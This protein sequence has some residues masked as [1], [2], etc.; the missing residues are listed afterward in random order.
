MKRPRILALGEILWDLFPEGERLGGAPANFACHVA[1]LGGDVSILSA[2]GEDDRGRRALGILQHYGVDTSLVE[3]VPDVPTGTVGVTVDG[4]GKPS[5]TIYPGAAWDG[6]RWNAAIESQLDRTDAVYFGTLGQRCEKSKSTLRRV[7]DV[8]MAASIPRVLD[9]NL[10][11]PFY[12]ARLI[13]ESIEAASILKLSDEELD[14]VCSAVEIPKDKSCDTRLRLLMSKMHLDMV[15]LTRGAEGAMLVS[16]E[17]GFQ[18]PAVTTTVQDTVGAGDAF[19]AS[20]LL[21]MLADEP[22]AE[23]L[24]RACALAADT[25]AHAGALPVACRST[26][27]IL[28]NKTL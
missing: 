6:I 7:L 2:V 8:A 16:A 21:S 23:A 19:T 27:S 26:R 24:K 4:F 14:I 17:G 3:I 10:R 28:P 9:V 22:L 18:Q 20:I 1:L 13:R 12:D 25:C 5:F 11:A 15:V